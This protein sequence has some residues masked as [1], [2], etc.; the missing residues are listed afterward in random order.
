MLN[1]CAPSGSGGPQDSLQLGVGMGPGG[2]T[3]EAGQYLPLWRAA[4]SASGSWRGSS[5]GSVS[6]PR[7]VR[8]GWRCRLGSTDSHLCFCCS[9]GRE[10]RPHDA[11]AQSCTACCSSSELGVLLQ[12]GVCASLTGLWVSF[13]P[14]SPAL[15]WVWGYPVILRALCSGTFF[16]LPG[17]SCLSS[18]CGLHR[19]SSGRLPPSTFLAFCWG[20]TQQC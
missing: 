14:L 9:G 12:L 10:R 8:R 16:L 19:T 15:G 17:G 1:S 7:Q 18:K 5:P 6:E 4:A 3:Q 20:H 2:S 11:P 13:L